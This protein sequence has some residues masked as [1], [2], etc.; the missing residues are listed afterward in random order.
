MNSFIKMTTRRY[1]TF[2]NVALL[3][4]TCCK[5]AMEKVAV[6]PVPDCA[7]AITSRPL[8]LG[9]MARCW[10]ADGFSKP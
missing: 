9:T 3:K 6:F 2:F 7:W 8:M 5:M 4:C 10:M 1:W